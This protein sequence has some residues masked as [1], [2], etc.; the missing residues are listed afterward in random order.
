MSIKIQQ[1]TITEIKKAIEGADYI[2]IGAGA[3]LSASAGLNY[4]DEAFFSEAYKPFLKKGYKTI[5]EAISGNWK[6]TTFSSQKYWGF[7]AYHANQI[8]YNPNQSTVYKNLYDLIKNKDYYVITT[9]CDGQ[10][11]KGGFDPK[12]IFAMQGSYGLYQCS[13]PCTDD[14]YDN[15]VMIRNMLDGFNADTLKIRKEDIPKCPN[16][17]RPLTTN[18]RI[19]DR[20]VDKP[21]LVNAGLYSSFVNQAIDKKLVL[22]ELGVGFNTPVIIRFPFEKL[23]YDNENITLIRMNTFKPQIGM[24]LDGRA[25]SIDDDIAEVLERLVIPRPYE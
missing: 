19:D 9:N 5:W 25:Y 13:K 23:A 11:Y 2:I 3:G 4:A 15:E 6:Q 24:K 12:R 22:L 18:L 10:F 8:F 20:F 16:C 17:G 21:H 1:K 7:W 14:V